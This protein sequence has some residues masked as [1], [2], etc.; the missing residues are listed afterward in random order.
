MNVT[1]HDELNFVFQ[2]VLVRDLFCGEISN[3]VVSLVRQQLRS[4]FTSY[5]VAKNAL[6]TVK[7]L[8]ARSGDSGVVYT[9]VI[10]GFFV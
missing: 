5:S 10:C 6:L 4:N 2:K 8:C 3:N 9:C 7:A 1:T